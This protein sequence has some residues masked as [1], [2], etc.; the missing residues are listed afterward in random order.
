MLRNEPRRLKAAIILGAKDN[1]YSLT[2][3]CKTSTQLNDLK[4]Y[5][6]RERK[7]GNVPF[8]L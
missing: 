8:F 2:G 3:E 4:G 5:C 6:V 1:S 7:G